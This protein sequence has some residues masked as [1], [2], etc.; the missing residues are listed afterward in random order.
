VNGIGRNII[1]AIY[2]RLPGK[3]E[4]K[5]ENRITKFQHK[6]KPLSLDQPARCVGVHFT[7]EKHLI[8]FKTANYFNGLHKY[9]C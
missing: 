7:R 9:I 2:R 8:T 5:S 3:S 4:E 6:T 1:E